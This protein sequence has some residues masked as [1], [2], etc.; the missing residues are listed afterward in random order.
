[1]RA[2]ITG[3]SG[4]VGRSLHQH[5]LDSGD[6]VVALA[7][8]TGGPDITDRAGIRAAVADA[9]ADVIY[10]LAAQSHVPTSWDDPIGTLR[11]NVEGTQNILDAAHES[12]E[13]RVLVVTSAEIYGSVSIDEL[14]IS[15]DAPMRPANPYA[16]SK[17]A[18]DA[19]AMQA[20]LGRGQ[21]VLRLRSFNHIGPGQSPDFVCAGLAHR[22][23]LAE[24]DGRSTIEVGSLEARRDFSDVRDIVAGYRRVARRGRSGA[25]YNL[26]SGID[27][28]IQDLAD[29]LASLSEHPVEFVVDDELRRPV[30]T[31]VVRGDNTR[32]VSD[33]GWSPTIP[34]ETSLADVL[35]DARKRVDGD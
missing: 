4:F 33:T 28:S 2:L 6:D 19:V 32:I 21:D 16:A 14:P 35:A 12:G 22:I 1:M 7:R 18:A 9:E 11:A 13:A 17:A 8:R 20:N 5:L 29:T 15:E 30:D 26:C 27:R 23:A 24:R 34:L 3:A 31:P 25:A 10:H